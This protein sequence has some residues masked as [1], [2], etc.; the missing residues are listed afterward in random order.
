M[1]AQIHVDPEALY[2]TAR[3]MWQRDLQ[4]V[5]SIYL[6]QAACYR[7]EMAWQ[8]D[9]AE[10]YV[11]ELQALIGQ[12]RAQLGEVDRFSLILSRQA[13]RWQESDQAW[14]R[15]FREGIFGKGF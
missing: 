6:L 5:E 15:A 7:L 13:E 10:V 12:L 14:A 11:N 3:E 9:S 8:G 1:T 4:M 2:I